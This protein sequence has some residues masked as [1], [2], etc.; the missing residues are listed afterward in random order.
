MV[1]AKIGHYGLNWRQGA[2]KYWK[3]YWRY[4]RFF[5]IEGSYSMMDLHP[6]L[7]TEKHAF[8]T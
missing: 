7:V 2:R 4:P 5:K 1:A 3:S 6:A 8:S